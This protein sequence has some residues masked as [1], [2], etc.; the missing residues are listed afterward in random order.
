[1][2]HD[3]RADYLQL[4]LLAEQFPL[5]P[6]IALTATADQRTR[7]EIIERLQF[8]HARQFIAGFDRPNIRY[9]IVQKEN[10]R[11]QLLK[12]ILDEHPRDAGIVYCLSRKKTEAVADWLCKQASKHCLIMPDCRPLCGK[13]IKAGFAGGRGHYGC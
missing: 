12:F 2:G 6:R 11:A 8:K 7:Q 9:C 13:R 3:F 10:A 4:S 1:M 5:V